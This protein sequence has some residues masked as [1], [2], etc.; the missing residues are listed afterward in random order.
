MSEPKC[1]KCGNEAVRTETRFGPRHT[2]CDLWSWGG[3]PL[4]DKDTHAARV[5]A[6]AAFD[7]LWRSGSM[8]RGKA[9]KSLAD[10][11]RIPL[12][13]CHIKTMPHEMASRVPRIAL[14]IEDEL[15]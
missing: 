15:S 8:S 3:A 4:V 13:D 1:P 6:H 5:D 2:C 12:K 7:R 9:Y 10:K 14:E 11:L